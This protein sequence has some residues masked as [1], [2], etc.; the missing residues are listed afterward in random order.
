MRG[1]VS[2]S[3]RALIRNTRGAP[4]AVCAE[5]FEPS[6]NKSE[7]AASVLVI[8]VVSGQSSVSVI[9][10]SEQLQMTWAAI[11]NNW[12]Y[13]LS[14]PVAARIASTTARIASPAIRPEARGI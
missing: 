2:A 13:G 8:R 9:K 1:L 4:A 14:H 7:M 11:D 3:L 12:T 6:R 10:I 5:R